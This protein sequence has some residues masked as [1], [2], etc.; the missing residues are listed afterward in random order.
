VGKLLSQKVGA[1]QLRSDVMIKH[2]GGP[3]PN[4]KAAKRIYSFEMS[5]KT[6][7]SLRSRDNFK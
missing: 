1:I 5:L 7:G 3:I 2:F 4:K 6:Y